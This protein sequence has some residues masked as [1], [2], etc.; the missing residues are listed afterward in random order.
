MCVASSEQ[1]SRAGVF[2]RT[3]GSMDRIAELAVRGGGRCEMFGNNQ[4]RRSDVW[5][6]VANITSL[7]PA[8]PRLMKHL[9]SL[10]LSLSLSP[11]RRDADAAVSTVSKLKTFT[12]AEVEEEDKSGRRARSSFITVPLSSHSDLGSGSY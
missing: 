7:I 10:F 11:I 5:W 9:L 1:P 6:T 12:G 2:P 4:L 3:H 8:R